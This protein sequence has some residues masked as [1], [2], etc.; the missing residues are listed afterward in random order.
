MTMTVPAPCTA[1]CDVHPDFRR[2]V[3]SAAWTIV[4]IK[5]ADELLMSALGQKRTFGRFIAMSALPPKADITER[6]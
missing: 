2:S 3:N 5:I 6:D 1:G 4:P